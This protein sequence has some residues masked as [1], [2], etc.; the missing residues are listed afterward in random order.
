MAGASNPLMRLATLL[1]VVDM[2][3]SPPSKEGLGE[4]SS[5]GETRP[6]GAGVL[7]FLP[8]LSFHFE[9]FFVT[10]GGGTTAV[11]GTGGLRLLL[12][13]GAVS[14]AEGRGKMETGSNGS[15]ARLEDTEALDTDL[16]ADDDLDALL[17][18]RARDWE[19]LAS[20]ANMSSMASGDALPLPLRAPRFRRLFVD[21][22][23]SSI[24]SCAG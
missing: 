7:L 13:R 10:G 12:V 14:K 4:A 3:L 18:S 11:G 17:T 19:A 8:K 15:W 21:V 16:W 22:D 1:A 24:D 23:L 20:V 6:G 5:T 2:A 9:G